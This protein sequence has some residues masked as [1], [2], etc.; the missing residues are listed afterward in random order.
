M[1]ITDEEHVDERLL[2]VGLQP[3]DDYLAEIAEMCA[4]DV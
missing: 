4:E 3:W 1:P 2:E